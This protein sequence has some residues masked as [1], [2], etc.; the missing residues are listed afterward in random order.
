MRP[1]SI[2][3]T[4]PHVALEIRKK[5]SKDVRYAN[6]MMFLDVMSIFQI[7]LP[8]WKTLGQPLADSLVQRITDRMMLEDLI[9]AK[10]INFSERLVPLI[11]LSTKA[12]GN[13][14]MHSISLFIWG[15]H[16]SNPIFLRKLMHSALQQDSK[17][18]YK[19]RWKWRLKNQISLDSSQSFSSDWES[20]VSAA[21]PIKEEG[22]PFPYLEDIHIFVI[23]Q[24]LRRPI[25]VLSE[26]VIRGVH[27]HSISPNTLHGVYLPVLWDSKRCCKSQIGR[28]SCRER[29]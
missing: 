20:V 23:C 28:A 9:L 21:S 13:C 5:I 10:V 19:N 24:I 6:E 7:T 25:I 14:L 4:C 1:R 12:D 27:G 17:K 16:D 8:P 18:E 3:A 2:S 15:I 29:V 26:P 22:K 11:P